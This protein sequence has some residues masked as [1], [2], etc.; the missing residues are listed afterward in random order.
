MKRQQESGQGMV[1]Y[2]AHHRVI[3]ILRRK[4]DCLPK[5]ATKYEL[6]N[7]KT[8]NKCHRN[9]VC[10]LLTMKGYLLKLFL[11]PKFEL[12]FEFD[13]GNLQKEG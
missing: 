7:I 10:V 8:K 1:L 11:K 2:W 5:N 3:T 13:G 4:T 6:P 9:Q 12:V